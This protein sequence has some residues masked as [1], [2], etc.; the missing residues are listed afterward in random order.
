MF[1]PL[2]QSIIDREGYTVVTQETL[3]DVLAGSEFVMLFF[4]GDA[5]RL[6]ESN[7][8]A[9]VFPELDRVLAGRVTPLVVDRKSERDLQRRYLF[10]MFPSIVFLRH[11]QYLGVISGILDWSDYLEQIPDILAREPGT[12]PP[13]R[14]PEGCGA[15][16]EGLPN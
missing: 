6:A 11:G 3:D 8:V 12:P 7:D 13:F 15:V 4:A 5:A 14:F 2:L 10:N 9:V 1:S 16:P